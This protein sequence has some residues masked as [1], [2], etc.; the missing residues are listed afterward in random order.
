MPR[1]YRTLWLVSVTSLLTD[2]SSEMVYPLVPMFLSTVLGA[3]PAALGVIEGVAECVASVVKIVSGRWSDRL[4][5][6]K[7]LAVGGYAG[8]A[9]GKVVLYL[10]VNWPLVLVARVIDRF[11]KGVRGAPRDALL[12]ESVPKEELGHAFGFHRAMDTIGAVIGVLIAYLL[13]SSR[14]ETP[15]RMVF[16]LSVI[17]AVLGVVALAM[18]REKAPHAGVVKAPVKLS[19]AGFRSL[20]PKLRAFLVITLVFA[21]GNSSNQ[22]L[23]LR[24]GQLGHGPAAVVL[25]YLMFNLTYASASYPAGWLSDRIGRRAV[26]AAGYLVYGVT[27]LAFGAWRDP[28]APWVLMPVY[29]LYAGLTDGVEKALLAELSPTDQKATVM[30]LHAAIVGVG[31]LPASVVTGVLWTYVGPLAAFGLGGVLGL[32][33]A[34]ALWMSLRGSGSAGSRE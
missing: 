24:A 4:G 14:S 21:L 13:I 10:A 32:A 19:L 11:G 33:A 1:V 5:N 15:Y 2:V 12:A 16:L 31:V 29:G 20:S 23:L 22:F 3:T 6:R 17:P 30:G 25:M 26:L 8:S 9:V 27:Y 34:V 28:T 18:V 7:V